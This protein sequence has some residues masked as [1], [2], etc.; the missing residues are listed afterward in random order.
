MTVGGKQDTSK[1][2]SRDRP[3]RQAVWPVGP[4]TELR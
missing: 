2:R 1:K 3:E 4:R